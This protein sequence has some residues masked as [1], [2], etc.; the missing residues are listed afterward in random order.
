[1]K[2]ALAFIAL[3]LAI[4]PARPATAQ[5]A[6]PAVTH[7]AEAIRIPTISHQDPEQV[8]TAAFDTFL[9]YLEDTYPTAFE[10]LEV[11]RVNGYSLL[12]RWPGA[13]DDLP[14]VLFDA[15][16]DVV[17]I[18]P[19]TEA[20]WTHPPFSG[21][22]AD[23]YV[24]GRGSIDDKVAV[25]VTLEALESLTAEGF[26][27]ERTLYF[28]FVHDEE[29]GG[30]QGAGGVVE[31]LE[32][33]GVRFA[34]VVGEGGGLMQDSP[35]L[36]G[37]DVAM[38]GLAEKTYLTLTLRSSGKGGHSSTP[39]R[40]S[41]IV[42]LA[43]ALQKLHENPFDAR[44]VSPVDDLLRALGQHQGGV[45]GWMLRNQWISK[46]LLVSQLAADPMGDDDRRRDQGERRPAARGGPRQLS[47]P[48]R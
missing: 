46:P 17:P 4:G 26:R 7:L 3:L 22:T 19:G 40:D 28:S 18:E 12:M 31:V 42:R 5:E 33:R 39:P 27:P 20:D 44:L 11:E 9:A 47:R 38:I 35:L 34:Y 25:I 41:S 21:A 29:V 15:H 10:T 43:K 24:W 16:Y 37:R 2:R 23:G 6:A 32:G 8:D 13:Q 30:E 36:P 14:P 1:M 45:T 48:S